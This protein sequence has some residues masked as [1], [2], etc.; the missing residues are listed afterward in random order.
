MARISWPRNSETRYPYGP[1]SPDPDRLEP[2]GFPPPW[3]HRPWIYGNVIASQNGILTWK[4]AGA[5]DDPVRAIAGGDFTRAGRLADLQFMRHLR[6]CADAV[7]FGAQT[8]RDQ[9]D[10]I[11]TPEDVGGGLGEALHRFRVRHGLRRLP[12]QVLYSESGR[13]SLD[14]PMFTTPGLAVIIVTTGPGAGRLR[15]QGADEQ[16]ITIFVAGEERIDSIGLTRFH[17]H[18]FD[19]FGVRYLDCEGGAVTLQSLHRAGLLDEM[20]V[21][22]TDI[23]VEPG[24]RM[25]VKRIFEFEAEA[26]RLVAEGQTAADPGYVFCRWR[27]NPR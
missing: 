25:G 7:S 9:P 20:F 22:V 24:E 15:A 13:L 10:L 1:A 23:H 6:A 2:L 5:H 11:G 26:A 8:L 16:G 4:R 14:G 21:T 18:L 12:L 27:F 3:P 17:E 19:E